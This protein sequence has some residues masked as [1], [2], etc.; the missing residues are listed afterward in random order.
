LVQNNLQP[1]VM[2]E[3]GCM[4]VGEKMELTRENW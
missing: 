2:I 4:M 3:N 1:W